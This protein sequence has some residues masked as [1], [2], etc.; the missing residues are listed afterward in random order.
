M[1]IIRHAWGFHS[2]YA[3]NRRKQT[4]F[5]KCHCVTKSLFCCCCC[6]SAGHVAKEETGERR[7]LRGN[8]LCERLSRPTEN[9]V[10]ILMPCLPPSKHQRAHAAYRG[11][12][13]P[14]VRRSVL[15]SLCQA[16]NSSFSINI[17]AFIQSIRVY[18]L[19]SMEMASK[20]VHT[21][22]HQHNSD[23]RQWDFDF[24]QCESLL[25]RSEKR[26]IRSLNLRSDLHRL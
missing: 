3:P 17:C 18:W 25:K 24:S 1:N 20:N 9:G 26:K 16:I 19:C 5:P 6:C 23:K 11:A 13:A 10:L 2:K 7:Q 12:I 15:S 22:T 8:A 14:N 4:K 21:H